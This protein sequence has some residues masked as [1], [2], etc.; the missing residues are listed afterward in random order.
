M[1]I[2]EKE[3]ISYWPRRKDS[4]SKEKP[5]SPHNSQF[6]KMCTPVSCA[7]V[8]GAAGGKIKRG[9]EEMKMQ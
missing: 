7:E 5:E 9:Q 2:E 8:R 1:G 4:Y 3:I 6:V